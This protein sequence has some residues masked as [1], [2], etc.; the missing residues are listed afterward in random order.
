MEVAAGVAETRELHLSSGRDMDMV[1]WTLAS[2]AANGM[3]VLRMFAHGVRP[4]FPL[5]IS[6]GGHIAQSVGSENAHA[7][8]TPLVMQ[9][10]LQFPFWKSQQSWLKA[11]AQHSIRLPLT[12]PANNDLR[13]AFNCCSSSFCQLMISTEEFGVEGNG[14]HH[15][16]ETE[17]PCAER[18]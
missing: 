13:T 3:N 17:P 16:G 7:L 8:F 14:T 4:D 15:C 1:Q 5:Q 10:L 12:W 18:W 11:V 6:P 2:A 9:L